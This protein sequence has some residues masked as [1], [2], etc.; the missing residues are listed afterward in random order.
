MTK[1]TEAYLYNKMK[2]DEIKAEKRAEEQ[3]R[4]LTETALSVM[5]WASWSMKQHTEEEIRQKI[6]KDIN[7]V[8]F[9]YL[10]RYC[11]MS[12]EFIEELFILSTGLVTETN[13]DQYYDLVKDAMLYKIGATDVK[14]SPVIINIRK[15]D[16]RL[17]SK[18][19]AE[20]DDRIDWSYISQYQNLTEDFIRKYSEVLDWSHLVKNQKLSRKFLKEFEYKLTALNKKDISEDSK[21]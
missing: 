13:R 1:H 16:G 17:I 20:W 6:Y 3:K 8:C 15:G 4:N 18:E 5:E 12:C 14:P 9:T 11:K 19:I 7:D 21:E 2:A 10:C